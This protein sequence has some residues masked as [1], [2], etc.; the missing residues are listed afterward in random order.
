MNAFKITLNDGSD[1]TTG[2][3]ATIE[4]AKKYFLGHLINIGRGEH[5]YMATCIN[6]EQVEP[7]TRMYQI[8][9]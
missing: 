6:V 7:L 3:N 9:N 2:M 4:E 5:D 1:Y 8:A